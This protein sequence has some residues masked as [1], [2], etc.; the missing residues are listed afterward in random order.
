MAWTERLTKT[1]GNLQLN[2]GTTQSGALRVKNVSI[3]PL[4]PNA[5]DLNKYA[6]IANAMSDFFTKDLSSL[7]VVK[8]YY[9][10]SDE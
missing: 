10:M 8:T 7:Q 9:V 1:V 4:N 2:N 3:G 5:W 6:E